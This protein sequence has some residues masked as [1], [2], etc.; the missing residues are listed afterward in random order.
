MYYS[1]NLWGRILLEKLTGSELV[2]KLPEF[3]GKRRFIIAF[4]TASHLSLSWAR[5]IQS[6]PPIYAWIFQVVLSLRFPHQNPG[7]TSP[8]PHSCY[9]PRTPHSHR[10]MYYMRKYKVVKFSASL[11]SVIQLNALYNQ[12]IHCSYSVNNIKYDV[13]RRT[14]TLWSYAAT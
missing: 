12:P 10:Y 13:Q 4:S 14:C 3:Y 2:E 8:L 11:D 6:M 7:H 1:I 9:M 5:S